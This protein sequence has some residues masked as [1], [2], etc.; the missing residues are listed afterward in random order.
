MKFTEQLEKALKYFSDEV[1]DSNFMFCVR[2][3]RI[4]LDGQRNISKWFVKLFLSRSDLKLIISV[5]SYFALLFKVIT[6]CLVTFCYIFNEFEKLNESN[7]PEN[8]STFRKLRFFFKS[9][10]YLFDFYLVIRI[11]NYAIKNG[12]IHKDFGELVIKLLEEKLSEIF[13]LSSKI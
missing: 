13:Y 5:L 2:S 8:V 9:K 11:G 10:R 1:L 6:W 4:I 12:S 7:F 3:L